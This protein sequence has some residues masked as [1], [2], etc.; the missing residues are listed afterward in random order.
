LRAL[1]DSLDRERAQLRQMHRVKECLVA[2]A[3]KLQVASKALENDEITIKNLRKDLMESQKISHEAVSKQEIATDLI[4]AL[5]LEIIQLNRRMKD[6]QSGD[7]VTHSIP[8]STIYQEADNEVE[9]MMLKKG[10]H[11]QQSDGLDT[12]HGKHKKQDPIGDNRPTDFQEWKMKKFLWAPDTP[13]GSVHHDPEVVSEML[14]AALH[15]EE[16]TGILRKS[17][18]SIA[19]QRYQTFKYS[20]DINKSPKALP[21][22]KTFS[23]KNLRSSQQN[24]DD[25]FLKEFK[26]TV[27]LSQSKELRPKTTQNF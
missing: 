25:D 4:Q 2:T 1:T 26:N 5:R 23:K 8:Q 12:D 15:P 27:A 17:K 6:Q 11:F 18:S 16:G 24:I 7:D 10:I 3:L 9:R 21:S 13:G 14:H 22:V 19:K 20:E